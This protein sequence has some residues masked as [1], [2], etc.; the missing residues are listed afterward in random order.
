[1]SSIYRILDDG[2]TISIPQEETD[3]IK[4]FEDMFNE[5]PN[6]LEEDDLEHT[7]KVTLMN[8]SIGV[9]L[10]ACKKSFK[11]ARIA[12]LQ[13]IFTQHKCKEIN[14]NVLKRWIKQKFEKKESE[15]LIPYLEIENNDNIKVLKN[16]KV[17]KFLN[18]QLEGI[19]DITSYRINKKGETFFNLV[20]P[21]TKK[22][23]I[24][25]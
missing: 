16:F 3:L 18:N 10:Q 13:K 8:F 17:L 1:M 4:K 15:V 21:D 12:L 2:K 25:I 14:P 9:C 22:I 23:I 24:N 5:T 11:E 20:N 19:V 6:F 7:C